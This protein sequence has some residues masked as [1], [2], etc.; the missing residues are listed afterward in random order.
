M[1]DSSEISVKL[2]NSEKHSTGRVYLASSYDAV[3]VAATTT[4]FSPSSRSSYPTSNTNTPPSSDIIFHISSREIST[5]DDWH[6]PLRPWHRQCSALIESSNVTTLPSSI[7][8]SSVPFLLLLQITPLNTYVYFRLLSNFSFF[9]LLFSTFFSSTL[10]FPNP[11]EFA[12]IISVTPSSGLGLRPYRFARI[13]KANRGISLNVWW[14]NQSDLLLMEKAFTIRT[15][16]LS[17]TNSPLL[18]FQ[19]LLPTSPYMCICIIESYFILLR[20]SCLCECSIFSCE[21]VAIK[22]HVKCRRRCRMGLAAKER[23]KE[24]E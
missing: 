2:P 13:T 9:S 17:C 16:Q 12:T 5:I 24:R 20:K 18:S 21:I 7:L 11:L 3:T 10:L 14:Q 15:F 8:T 6:L 23:D 1:S 4:L 19:R 22:I